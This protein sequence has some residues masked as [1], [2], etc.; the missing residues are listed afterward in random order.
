MHVSLSVQVLAKLEVKSLCK[1]DPHHN[2]SCFQ[3][4]QNH[5][6]SCHS[7]PVIYTSLN[8][9]AQTF[10]YTQHHKREN[11]FHNWKRRDSQ[12]DVQ[13]KFMEQKPSLLKCY[14]GSCHVCLASTLSTLAVT[15]D[16]PCSLETHW[17]W[18]HTEKEVSIKVGHL[19][20]GCR[21]SFKRVHIFQNVTVLPSFEVDTQNKMQ[22]GARI[23][24]VRWERWRVAEAAR[25]ALPAGQLSV[26]GLRDELNLPCTQ[27]QSVHP[28]QVCMHAWKH[29]YI[30][31][32]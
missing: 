1:L 28:L 20:H 17:M 29:K 8:F 21:L 11:M 19:D 32:I 26:I 12:R 4:G 7:G 10:R 31:Y 3:T 15:E 18:I 6:S 24:T 9:M 23:F 5:S 16:E 13:S 22:Q 2:N 30:L 25:W 14:C 27:I